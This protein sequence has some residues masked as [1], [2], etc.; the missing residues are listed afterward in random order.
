MLLQG[1]GKLINIVKSHIRTYLTEIFELIHNLWDE[2]SYTLIMMRAIRNNNKQIENN[3][4]HNHHHHHHNK[5]ININ[6]N[7]NRRSYHPYY[8]HPSSFMVPTAEPQLNNQSVSF[9]TD[10]NITSNNDDILYQHVRNRS[11]SFGPFGNGFFGSIHNNMI[12]NSGMMHMDRSSSVISDHNNHHT[13]SHSIEEKKQ[14]YEDNNGHIN[15]NK[16]KTLNLPSQIN[17]KSHYELQ[18][19]LLYVLIEICR[20]IQDEF[21]QYLHKLLP[22]LLMILTRYNRPN[23]HGHSHNSH[24]NINE[25]CTLSAL[26][27]LTIFGTN[28]Q[29]FLFLV[30][31]P[32]ME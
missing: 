19:M 27:A 26:N 14:E 7:N 11:D 22:K 4:N 18:D 8:N 17:I 13:M 9:D 30:L 12:H 6:N 16:K 21:K 3:N 1:L 24:N 28:L 20:A 25:R 31:P 29:D 32:I 23:N 2:N 15:K 5:Q 10:I